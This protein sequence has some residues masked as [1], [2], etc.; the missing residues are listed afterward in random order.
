MRNTE[1][2]THE[3]EK[4]RPGQT[5][6][7]RAGRMTRLLD[8]LCI[9]ALLTLMVATLWEIIAVVAGGDVPG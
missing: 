7:F 9:A 2:V 8:V 5:L 4:R 6:K 1:Q 3:A